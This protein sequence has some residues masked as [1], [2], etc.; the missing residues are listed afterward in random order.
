M[1]LDRITLSHFRNHP[2]SRLDATRHFNLLVGQNG[3]GKTNILEALS[4]LAPGRGLRRA[5]LA[6]MAAQGG[7]AGFAVSAE[8]HTGDGEPVLLATGTRSERPTRRQVRIN[9][10]DAPAITLGE[11][12]SI[13]WLTPAMDRIFAD[14]AAERRRFMD[15]LSLGLDPAHARHCA[16]YEK[17]LSERNRLFGAEDEPDPV[18]LDAVEGQMADA[19]AA[20]WAARAGL[21][22]ALET[23]LQAQGDGPFARPTLAHLA[24]ADQGRDA[25]AAELRGTRTRDRAA[26][27]TLAGPHRDDLGVRL[28]QKDMAAAICST[29]EQKAMLIAIILAHAS[30]AARGR[31][32]IVLLD[33][34]AAHL[35]PERRAALFDRLR[36]GAAQVWMTGTEQAPF[37]T[38]ADEAAIWRVAGG[39]VERLG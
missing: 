18:W 10:A 3:A 14:G 5:G 27:R 11:W 24:A 13:S 2:A 9:G 34:I 7:S 8:L 33:E 19:G 35:D 12:L 32:G 4:L 28:A 39:R 23:E 31:S 29:G 16:L 36:D 1:P 6:E 21:V 17:A 25:L 38:I 22:A 15:R 30:L 37:E 26:R 20:V